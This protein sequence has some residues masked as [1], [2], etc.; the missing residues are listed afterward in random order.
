MLYDAER[1]LLAIA[2]FLVEN[3]CKMV[4]CERRCEYCYDIVSC[5]RPDAKQ[6]VVVVSYWSLEQFPLEP[7]EWAFF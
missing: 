3:T 4:Y 5:Y 1:D 7:V 6:G 2:K